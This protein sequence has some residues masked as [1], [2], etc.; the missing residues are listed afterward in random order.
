MFRHCPLIAFQLCIRPALVVNFVLA[1]TGWQGT[2]QVSSGEKLGRVRLCLEMVRPCSTMAHLDHGASL[3]SKE[4]QMDHALAE[5]GHK[6]R[7]TCFVYHI[8]PPL[9]SPHSD[10]TFYRIETHNCCQSHIGG[11]LFSIGSAGSSPVHVCEARLGL[12]R[13]RLGLAGLNYGSAKLVP[14]S[15]SARHTSIMKRSTPGMLP[16]RCLPHLFF[17]ALCVGVTLLTGGAHIY[18]ERETDRDGEIER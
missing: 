18:R 8:L 1:G 16:M 6:E 2:A 9:A 14:A 15:S 12:T 5:L 13:P 17:T 11:K 4:S 10:D 7:P 3:L